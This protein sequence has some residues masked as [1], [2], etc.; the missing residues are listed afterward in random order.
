MAGTHTLKHWAT[1]QSTIA[2]SSGEAELTGLVKG[3]SHGLGMQSVARDLGVD[4]GLHLRSDATAAIGICRRRGLG[5]VRHLSTADLWIQE[6]LKDEA[7]VLT[8]IS[9]PENP[10]DLLT[11]HVERPVLRT[12]LP[13]LSLVFESGRPESAPKL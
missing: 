10:A 13:K 6:K 8:K 2:L 7:F 4:L 12:L 1:T 9:G 5:K 3:A 11:K